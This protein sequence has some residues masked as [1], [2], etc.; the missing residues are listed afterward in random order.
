[1]IGNKR[2]LFAIRAVG[3][4]MNQANVDNKNIEDGDFVI[5]DPSDKDYRSNDYVLTIIDDCANIKRL[6][7]NKS[8]GQIALLSESTYNYPPI[9]IAEDETARFLINGKAVQVIK[10]TI[11]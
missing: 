1:L 11:I 9:I 10:S 3:A 4:S 7:I 8:A 6:S 5:I 2:N